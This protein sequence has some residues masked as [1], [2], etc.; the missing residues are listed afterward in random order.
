MNE[1]EFRKINAEAS[2]REKVCEHKTLRFGSSDYYLF[3]GDC[4]RAWVHSE[5]GKDVPCY[6]HGV[7]L[8]GQERKA[9]Q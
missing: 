5:H 4:A 7:N 3:C 2:E 1:E 8:S 6:D 9:P